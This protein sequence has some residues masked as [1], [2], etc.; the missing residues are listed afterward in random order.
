[1]R[2]HEIINE[3]HHVLKRGQ[4]PDSPFEKEDT[5]TVYHGF[6]DIDDAILVAKYGTSG[7]KRANRVYSYESDNN[8]KGLFVTPDLETAKEFGSVVFEFD[9]NMS[10]LEPP[11]WP[12]GGYTVQG[13]YSQYWGHGREGRA[14]RASRQRDLR[15]Q[16]KSDERNPEWIK[17]SD[18]PLLA[19]TL[20]GMGERQALF[21]G[22]LNPKRIKRVYLRDFDR[23]TY[24]YT[25]DW[26]SLSPK[27]FLEK[28]PS[29]EYEKNEK[30]R[31]TKD[32]VFEPDEKFDGET[33]IERMSKRYGG[34][35]NI[36]ESLGNIW[37]AYVLD[38]KTNKG[39]AFNQQFKM[40]L[41]PKQI[42]DAFN[43]FKRKYG[44]KKGGD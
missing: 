28:Y 18:D 21:V 5:I 16:H 40:F 6:R 19:M 41:W 22:H 20:A 44:I 36:E 9:S 24:T 27:E 12:S 37:E 33:F 11:V 3:I 1:M 8:P 35:I 7:A 15:L 29:D 14:K 38:S 23:K 25:S 4:E 32:K 26:Y 34:R 43:W 2:Y 13:G 30:F 39:H 31:D 10:E 42:P 17:Q